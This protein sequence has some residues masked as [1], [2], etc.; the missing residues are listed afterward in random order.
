ML[1]RTVLT[2]LV[3][4]VALSALTACVPQSRDSFNR[5]VDALD[6]VP[7][8]T[9][10]DVGVSTPLPFSVHGSVD[11]SLAADQATFDELRT[12]A[13]E[14]EVNATVL[15]S[16]TV[17]AGATS[18]LVERVRPCDE[19]LVDQ[20]GLAA[21][22]EQF[23]VDMSLDD[24]VDTRV[25]VSGSENLAETIAVFRVVTDFLPATPVGLS[26]DEISLTAA[27]AGTAAAYLDDFTEL[28]AAFGVE[29]IDLDE[30]SLVI[31]VS[32]ASDAQGVRDF[33]AGRD[34]ERYAGLEIVVTDAAAGDVPAGT[35]AAVVEL[36][37]RLVADLGLS[38][39]IGGN[40][41]YV[42]AADS[43]EVVELSERIAAINSDAVKVGIVIY[44]G[45]GVA[46]FRQRHEPEL[47]PSHNPYPEWIEQYD[48][49]DAT[50]LV[51]TV[52]VS[53]GS[54]ETWLTETDYDDP[55]AFAAVRTVLDDLAD[56]YELTFW[57]LNNRDLT[58]G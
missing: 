30:E 52:E 36:R 13:C 5:Y 53:P 58:S 6:A 18:V 11:V 19:P 29:Q 45:G 34:A 33:L 31:Q 38:V 10:D 21:A 17:H 39:N 16:I 23:G 44:E 43:R 3:A 50:N 1:K 2:F 12:V 41:V 32:P 9:I 51:S 46:G 7:G 35:D 48:R 8:V 15:L 55:L 25:G 56:E 22:T 20:V 27:D 42:Q 54:L 28:V 26:G 4:T 37:D 14:T 49:L 40:T 24:V 47:T 57:G